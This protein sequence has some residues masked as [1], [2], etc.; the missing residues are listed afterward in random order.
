METEKH[1]FTLRVWQESLGEQRTEWRGRI[2]NLDSGEVRFFRNATTLY[3][4][5]LQ[6]LPEE[7]SN[8]RLAR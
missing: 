6:M 8:D 7:E 4:V 2:K 5:M 3:R 1:L